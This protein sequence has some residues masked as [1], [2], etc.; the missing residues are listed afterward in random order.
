MKK[1]IAATLLSLAASAS[2]ASCFGGPTHKTC[3]DDAGNS[4]QVSRFGNSTTVQGY[5]AGTG[6]TWEQTSS[7][8]GNSTY[9]QGTAANGQSWN[10]TTTAIGNQTT[11]YGTDSRGNYFQRTCGPYGCY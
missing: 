10:S 11:T 5:N 6:S 9:T 2:W 1:I 8:V 3:T 4:Y 7:R